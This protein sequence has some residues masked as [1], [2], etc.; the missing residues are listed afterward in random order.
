MMRWILWA[1]CCTALAGR[2]IRAADT[3]EQQKINT[4]VE[5]LTRLEN[6]NLDEKPAV[7]A[8]VDRVLA[9]TRGTPNFVKLVQHF[10]LTN[11][12]AGLLEVAIS[13][14]K[15]E[16]GVEAM[17]LVLAGRDLS[18]VKDAL[19]STNAA[20]ASSRRSATRRSRLTPRTSACRLV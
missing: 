16:S 10:K 13:N 11:Q 8:A 9:K 18:A 15:D 12:N 6:V 1:L 14:P 4:A 19:Q 17:R 3:D 5:A 7:K 20:R 2:A